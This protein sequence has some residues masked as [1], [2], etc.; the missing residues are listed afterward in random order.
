MHMCGTPMVE[1]ERD[2]ERV[3]H[4]F[5]DL[6]CVGDCSNMNK[7][8]DGCEI[9]TQTDANNCGGCGMAC[10]SN[11]VP[12]PSC[13]GGVCNGACSSGYAN[14]YAFVSELSYSNQCGMACSSHNVP[15]PSCSG[16]V[17][18]GACS[19]GYANWYALVSEFSY[20]NQCAD[21]EERRLAV[22]AP[23]GPTAA[24]STRKP[25]PTTA[26][27]VALLVPLARAVSQDHV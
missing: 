3:C 9:N 14:W 15:S 7:L 17:C 10:S 18:N 13:S 24:T 16:G 5:T 26:A 11:N 12:T 27:C 6:T 4:L 22:T 20:S 8:T 2:G 25:M 19:A 23:S 1:R 21:E